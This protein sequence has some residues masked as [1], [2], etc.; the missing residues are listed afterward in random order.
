MNQNHGYQQFPN[1][2]QG[3]QPQFGT[4]GQPTAPGAPQPP[5]KGKTS[6]VVL[7]V[8]GGLV[9]LGALGA[10]VDS[11][12][13]ETTATAVSTAPTTQAQSLGTFV[14]LTPKWTPSAAAP[15]PATP[16]APAAPAV[17]K[18]F[19]KD[20]TYKV[21]TEIQ[22]GEYSYTVTKKANGY[23]ALCTDTRCEVGEGMIDNDWIPTAGATG[24]LTIDESAAY[25]ELKGLVLAPA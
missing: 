17:P 10:A 7:G 20:G 3:P 19:T 22:P 23:W 1:P 9:V 14:P 13:S 18:A 2:N 15:A 24:Y 4:L 12:E 6:K 11:G 21:G 25:V 5:K 16:V 8:L